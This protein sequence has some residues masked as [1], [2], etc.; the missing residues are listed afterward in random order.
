MK[1]VSAA[2]LQV[3][4]DKPATHLWWD[5]SAWSTLVLIAAT[6]DQAVSISVTACK[7]RR[8]L[9]LVVQMR[10]C[11]AHSP[12]LSPEHMHECMMCKYLQVLPQ[13]HSCAEMHTWSSAMHSYL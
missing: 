5:C 11:S 3:V 9:L 2:S 4:Q 8:N 12:E 7:A 1:G 10:G 6:E 13:V